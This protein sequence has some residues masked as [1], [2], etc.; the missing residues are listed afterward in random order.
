MLDKQKYTSSN[1]FFMSF[2]PKKAISEKKYNPFKPQQDIYPFHILTF[3]LI[4]CVVTSFI[5]DVIHIFVLVVV[6]V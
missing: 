2:F 3:N 6:A 1:I 5:C 4:Y